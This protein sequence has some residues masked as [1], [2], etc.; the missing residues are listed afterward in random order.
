MTPQTRS[1]RLDEQSGHD[2][3]M[4][5]IHSLQRHYFTELGG[6]FNAP[7]THVESVCE[8]HSS[9]PPMSRDLSTFPGAVNTP[10]NFVSQ[11]DRADIFSAK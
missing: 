8:V 5:R 9:P 6:M 4:T 2:R 3:L 7:D 10:E 1:R 11:H